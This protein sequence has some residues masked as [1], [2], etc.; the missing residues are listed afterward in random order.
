M[1]FECLI[2]SIVPPSTIDLAATCHSLLC[3][4]SPLHLFQHLLPSLMSAM[5]GKSSFGPAAE[6]DG[7]KKQLAQLTVEWQT[8][9]HAIPPQKAAE[10]ILV[11][12]V[13]SSALIN[14]A[15]R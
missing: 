9:Q 7:L 4:L 14:A 12:S 6:L 13:P 3:I 5:D 1:F 2:R 8:V 11:Y 15:C 10:L